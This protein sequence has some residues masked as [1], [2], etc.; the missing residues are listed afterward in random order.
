VWRTWT[1]RLRG[2]VGKER[3]KLGAIEDGTKDPIWKSAECYVI[4][5]THK[6]RSD[7]ETETMVPAL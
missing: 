1:K 5:F 3:S 2:G 6:P 7:T 4:P